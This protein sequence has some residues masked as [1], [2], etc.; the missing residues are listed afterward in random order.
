[1]VLLIARGLVMEPEDMANLMIM[2]IA[3]GLM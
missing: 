2:M 3:K 1:M